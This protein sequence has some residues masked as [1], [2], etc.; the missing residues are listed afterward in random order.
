M[1][2]TLIGKIDKELGQVA[3]IHDKCEDVPF[4]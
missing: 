1:L 4:C 2:H 3:N